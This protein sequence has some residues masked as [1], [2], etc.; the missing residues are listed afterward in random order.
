M[1][2]DNFVLVSEYNMPDDFKCIWQKET[3]TNFD[4][5]RTNA[6]KRVEKLFT[7]NEVNNGL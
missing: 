5:N 2:K 4:S 7:L 6:S 1:S 3:T